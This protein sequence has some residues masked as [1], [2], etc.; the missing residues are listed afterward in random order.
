MYSFGCGVQQDKKQAFRF[1]LESAEKGYS[2]A[3]FNVAELYK[4]GT[5]VEKDHAM[6]VKYFKL[7]AEAGNMKAQANL[8]LLYRKGHGVKEDK[9]LAISYFRQAAAQGHKNSISHLL[10]SLND[11]VRECECE[12]KNDYFMATHYLFQILEVDNHEIQK[13]KIWQRNIDDSIHRIFF[14]RTRRQL[15][16]WSNILLSGCLAKITSCGQQ[17]LCT[18]NGGAHVDAAKFKLRF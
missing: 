13:V 11:L 5:G 1:Y 3:Q 8:G 10:H 7:A 16:N 14:G 15:Q 4:K 6:A 2:R 9:N 17:K 12:S 18:G